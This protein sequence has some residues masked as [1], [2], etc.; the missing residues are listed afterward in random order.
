MSALPFHSLFIEQTNQS[1]SPPIFLAPTSL[2]LNTANIRPPLFIQSLPFFDEN[3]EALEGTP[4]KL[5]R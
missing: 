4:R 3:S 2:S 1:L 5:Q